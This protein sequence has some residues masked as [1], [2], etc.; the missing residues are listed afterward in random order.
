MGKLLV[1]VLVPLI[2][3]ATTE[4][5]A[6]DCRTTSRD[7][8]SY[9]VYR[10]LFLPESL[11]VERDCEPTLSNPRE[12]QE[13]LLGSYPQRLRQ[14][15]IEG[16]VI[17][18]MK[19]GVTGRTEEIVIAKPSRYSSFDRAAERIVKDMKFLPASKNGEPTAVWIVQPIS[20]W[21]KE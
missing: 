15:G 4:L 18:L 16:Q 10:Q 13:Q 9:Q 14:Q 12:V 8:P 6:Q 3:V 1:V 19:V 11:Y 5:R 21:V 20:F 7:D 2:F 17:L